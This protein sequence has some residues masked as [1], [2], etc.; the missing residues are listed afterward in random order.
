M[1]ELQTRDD[2]QESRNYG[3][4]I[5]SRSLPRFADVGEAAAD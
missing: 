2:K 5:T 1:A 4:E 3:L